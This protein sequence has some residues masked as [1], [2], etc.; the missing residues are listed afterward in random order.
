MMYCMQS[1]MSYNFFLVSFTSSVL[2]HCHK[3]EIS[4]FVGFL[5]LLHKYS[6]LSFGSLAN[7]GDIIRSLVFRCL[8]DIY[9]VWFSWCLRILSSRSRLENKF[10]IIFL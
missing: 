7:F 8:F 6:A 3:N 4:I 5:V 1:I 9:G 10:N 2:A